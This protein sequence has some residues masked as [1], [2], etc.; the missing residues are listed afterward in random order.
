MNRLPIPVDDREWKPIWDELDREQRRR[1]K[2]AVRRA[3]P[4]PEVGYAALAVAYA[5]RWRRQLLVQMLLSFG[6]G[7][8]MV[9]VQLRIGPANPTFWYWW[10]WGIAAVWALIIPVL[11]A[12]RRSRLAL[13]E[14]LNREVVE[15]RDQ[16]Q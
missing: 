6:L 10:W 2:Q 4:L 11:G 15:G 13:A 1:V 3:Q 5:V 12:Y 14:K 8:L 9:T 7:L 16:R